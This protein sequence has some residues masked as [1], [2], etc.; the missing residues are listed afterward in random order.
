MSTR[1]SGGRSAISL[2]ISAPVGCL[3]DLDLL[4]AI[5]IAE[6]VGPGLRVGVLQHR[7]SFF[8][9][10]PLH[11]LRGAGRVQARRRIRASR[12]VVFGQHFPQF[13]KIE[14]VGHEGGIFRSEGEAGGAATGS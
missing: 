10:K 3:D 11:E 14:R 8:G 6:D 4:V 2:P 7:P 5:E 12:R 13:G 9:G 1:S